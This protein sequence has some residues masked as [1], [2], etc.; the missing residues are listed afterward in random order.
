MGKSNS[1]EPICPVDYLLCKWGSLT[2]EFPNHEEHYK[3]TNFAVFEFK[4][5]DV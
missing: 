1:L 4:D 3:T 5:F 2:P